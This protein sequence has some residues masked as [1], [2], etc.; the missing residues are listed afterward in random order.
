MPKPKV[1]LISPQAIG[2]RNQIRRVQP[3][4]GLGYIAAVLEARDCA[5]ILIIDAVVEGFD[6]IEPLEDDPALVKY[7]LP[8]SDLVDRVRRFRPDLI[9][10]SSLFSSQVGC[11]YAI[12]NALKESVPEIPIVFGGIHASSKC[13]EVLQNERSVDFVLT[14]EGDYTFAELLDRLVNKAD[15]RNIPG[16]VW[17]EGG[18]IQQNPSPAFIAKMD[19]LPFPAWHLMNMDR[20]F[21]IGLPHNPFLKSKQ[22]ACIMTSRG[23]PEHCYFCSSAEFFGHGFRGMSPQRVS[24]M[25]Q[26]AIDRFG[27][28]ELQ[29]EDDTFTLNHK[30]VIEICEALKSHKLRISTPNAV[31]ADAPIDHEKRLRMFKAMRE[32]GWEQIAFSVEHGDQDFLDKIIGKR[33]ELKEVIASCDIAHEAGLLVHA[34]F[35]IGFPHETAELRQKTVDFSKQ[36]DADSYSV[37]LATPLPGTRMWDLVEQDGLFMENFD[38]NRVL[39]SQV[40]IKPDDISPEDLF[41]VAENLNRELNASAQKKRPGSAEK[42]KLFLGKDAHGDRKYHHIAQGT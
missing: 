38:L 28:R 19:E 12:A 31:R 8:N 17:R 34:N 35:M 7:G 3:P 10:I 30:R 22:V 13:R 23:C 25:V 9:G 36:L 2:G 27:I 40:S 11:A 14:G 29:I 21:E 6:H 33:L 16:L 24:E 32:A 4:L 39:F 15:F 42:Y 26:Y 1:V 41:R 5:D 18:N 37:S 20:Y